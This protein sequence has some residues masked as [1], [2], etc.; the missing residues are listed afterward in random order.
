MLHFIGIAVVL[1]VIALFVAGVLLIKG[2]W[3]PFLDDEGNPVPF[4]QKEKWTI[5]ALLASLV[6]SVCSAFLSTNHPWVKK[7]KGKA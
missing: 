6:I 2:S 7:M 5:G 1:L 3:Q 4:T